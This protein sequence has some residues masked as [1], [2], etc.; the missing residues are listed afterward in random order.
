MIVNGTLSLC[1]FETRLCTIFRPIFEREANHSVTNFEEIG[2]FTLL[3]E[4]RLAAESFSP[5]TGPKITQGRVKLFTPRPMTATANCPGF[6]EIVPNSRR[7]QGP[8]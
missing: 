4:I 7:Q 2:T 1:L 8:N 6:V 3:E 5:Q